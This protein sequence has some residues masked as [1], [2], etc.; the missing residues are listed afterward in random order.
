MPYKI[1]QNKDKSFKVINKET[2]KVL[3]KH[4]TK[5]KAIKQIRLLNY[6]EH[7]K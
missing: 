7:K 3:A 2:K 4:T 5:T 6:L 1:L